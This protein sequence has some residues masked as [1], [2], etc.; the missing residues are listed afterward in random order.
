MDAELKVEL[1]RKYAIYFMQSIPI[2]LSVKSIKHLE[3]M[4]EIFQMLGVPIINENVKIDILLGVDDN[5]HSTSR[6]IAGDN[7]VSQRSVLRV[8]K[9]ETYHPYK[10]KLHQG[11]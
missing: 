7:G 6:Q 9:T 3:K 5:R 1:G 11:T 4:S 10:I 8:L 2:D